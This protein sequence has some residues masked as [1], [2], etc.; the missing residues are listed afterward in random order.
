L[1][2]KY[3]DID[4]YSSAVNNIKYHIP[5]DEKLPSLTDPITAPVFK[6]LIDINNIAV[7]VEDTT[8]GLKHRSEF[9]KEMFSLNRSITPAYDILNSKDQFIYGS[10]LIELLKLGLYIQLYEFS[11]GNKY[12]LKNAINNSSS[13]ISSVINSN[14]QTVVNNYLIYLRFLKKEE[15]LQ[16]DALKRYADGI[17]TYFP[18]L[19]NSFPSSNYTEM[20]TIINANLNS[21]KS[22]EIKESLSKLKVLLDEK[23][24]PE[25]KTEV[26]P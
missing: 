2:K 25:V 9:T 8:L 18:K 23:L 3:W 13:E 16:S 20:L 17:D 14:N 7:V 4:D 12:I 24:K 10:E 11:L 1:E 19:I 22:I 21:V 6:K 5:S 15:A 26:T